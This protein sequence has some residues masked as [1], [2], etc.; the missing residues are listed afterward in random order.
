MHLVTQ[1]IKDVWRK[2]QVALILFLDIQAAFPNTVKE[3]LL[4]NMKNR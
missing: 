3:H 4:Y 1:K 2:K